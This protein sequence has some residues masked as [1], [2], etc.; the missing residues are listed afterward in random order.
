MGL[1]QSAKDSAEGWETDIGFQIKQDNGRA[2]IILTY[3]DG[4]SAIADD[5]GKAY[6]RQ[7][8]AFVPQKFS[9]LAKYTWTSGSFKG[10]RIGGGIETESDKRY[11]A[12]LLE[13]PLLADAFAGYTFSNNLDLQLNLSNITDERYILQTAA[14][15]LVQAS[16]TFRAKLT[17]SYRW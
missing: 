16:D 13:R 15:G 14:N 17:V 12:F 6:V 2:D 5:E 7:T 10:L 11:G 4:D 3:F 8:N 1:I 9:A